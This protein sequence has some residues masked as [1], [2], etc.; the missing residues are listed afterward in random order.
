MAIKEHRTIHPKGTYLTAPAAKQFHTGDAR[1]LLATIDIDTLTG[2]T[3]TITFTIQDYDYASK[4][5]RTVLAST[6]LNAAG[7]TQLRVY[8]GLDETAN[9]AENNVIGQ[10]AR[11]LVA[12]GG[13][14]TN[15][16]WSLGVTLL[17]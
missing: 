14:V 7:V 1:G 13:T 9:A 4:E 8:P 12:Y 17:P 6:A 5:W 11:V 3:P 15:A 16:V 10:L 2:T